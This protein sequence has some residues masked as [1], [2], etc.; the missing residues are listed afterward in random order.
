MRVKG[1]ISAALCVACLGAQE[2][3]FLPA[4]TFPSPAYFRDHFATPKARVELQPPVRLQDFVVDSKLELSLR[5]YLELV[6]ANNTDIEIQRLSL[7]A[8][9]HNIL[10]QTGVLFDPALQAGFTSTRTKSPSTDVLQGAQTISQLSQPANF[11]YIQTLQSGTQMRVGFNASKLSTNSAFATFNPALNTNLSFNFTQPLLRGRG[12]YVTRLPIM[13]ARSQLRVSEYQLRDQLLRLLTQ[14]ENAYWD[15]VQAR[16]NVT[17]QEESL[18]L[19]EEAL[20]RAQRELELGALSQLEIFQPEAQFATAKLQVSQAQYRQAQLEDAL[21]RQIGADLD[22]DIRKLPVVLTETVLPPLGTAEIDKEAAVERALMLRPDLKAQLQSLDVDDLRIKS[23]SNAMRPD[24]S[25]TMGYTSQGRGGDF[26]QRENVFTEFGRTQ[27]VVRTIPGGI[28]DALDQMFGFNFPVYT[29][30]LQLRLPIRDRR[31][32]ADLADALVQKRTDA[33]R[34]RSV[35]QNIRLEVLNAVNQVESSKAAVELARVA[36]DL[37]RKDLDAEQKRYELGTS[38][39]TF[40]LQAQ[41]RLV[42]AES[43][44]LQESIGYRRGLL[45]LLRVTGELLE[46][47]G[48]VL[49]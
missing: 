42:T 18:R 34:A 3:P 5:S 6:L 15:V 41:A 8:P 14:A 37:A 48:V 19:S 22:P 40:L 4:P 13:I 49:P 25:L 45:T 43:R 32:A 31:A 16:E 17:V 7:E 20:K 30:G 9:K 46:E 21:R 44:L 35:E 28:G 2:L 26:F 38:I 12:P 27:A 36:R 39:L 11:S 10:R 29:F 1:I 47:R 23:T 24:L 33:L